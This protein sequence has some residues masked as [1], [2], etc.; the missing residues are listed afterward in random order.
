L[1]AVAF[2]T[3]GCKLNQLETESIADA[4]RKAGF[5]IDGSRPLLCIV[6]TCTVTSKAEQKARRIIRQCLGSGCAV[7]V[8]GCY[9][10]LEEKTL[11]K[12]LLEE[13]ALKKENAA[14]FIVPGQSKEKL[15]D[16]PRYLADGLKGALSNDLADGGVTTG[17]T[18]VQALLAP[19]LERWKPD[20]KKDPFS[21]NPQS[22]SFH[23]RAFL[24]IQDGCDRS[25]AYCRVPLARG[26]SVSLD[27]GEALN[28]LKALENAGIAEAVITGVNI[29][30]YRDPECPSRRLPGLL[31]ILLDNTVN[32]RLRLSSIEPEEGLFGAAPGMATEK[33]CDFFEILAHKRIRN[34]FHLSVQSGSDAVLKAMGRPYTAGNILWITEKLKSIRDDPFLACDIITGFPGETEDDFEQTVSLCKTVDFAWMH[35]F[36]YSRRP[37]TG[38]AALKKGLV[39]EKCAGERLDLLMELAKQGRNAYVRRWQGKIVEAVAESPHT[40]PAEAG[41]KSDFFPFFPA[42]T[43]NYIKVRVSLGNSC[44]G[45]EAGKAF[46]CRIGKQADE[47]ESTF[48]AWALLP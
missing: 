15:L 38:A 33:S 29:C 17:G 41:E 2:Y 35:I 9:A 28:R 25:C 11:K 26:K 24:K 21:F 12:V 3:L 19:L 27:S 8:T 6:N 36:P 1:F 14:L 32:I 46:L 37:G 10:Q 45:P 31:K 23:S 22:F 7:L 34:H 18:K 39:S 16:L 48:D 47:D 5:T 13:K 4:F 42:L 20:K 30:Q 43:D 40:M 44:N